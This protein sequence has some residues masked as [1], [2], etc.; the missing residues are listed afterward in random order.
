M[1]I[2][3]TMDRR[4]R[5]FDLGTGRLVWEDVLPASA[6]ATP[7]TYRAR[8]GGRQFIVLAVGGHDGMKTRL[9]DYLLAYAL[10]EEVAPSAAPREG[11]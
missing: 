11:P 2:A 9:G 7:M 4:F 8:A 5:A 6:Q 3:A 10:L 1:F